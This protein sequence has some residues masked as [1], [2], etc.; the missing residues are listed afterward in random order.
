MARARRKGAKQQ[1]QPEP[2]VVAPEFMHM[3]SLT[4]T[5]TPARAP[6][7]SPDAMRRSKSW[8]LA[9]ASSRKRLMKAPTV[10]SRRSIWANAASTAS[11][12]LIRPD[13]IAAR[14]SI[15]V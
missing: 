8:A 15:A 13:A 6:T 7:D 12:L 3:L 14:S 10:G 4:A 11:A 2:Q 9:S 1:H 5:G